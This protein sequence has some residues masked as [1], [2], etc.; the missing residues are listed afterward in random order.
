MTAPLIAEIVTFRIKPDADAHAFV[1]RAS[2]MMPILQEKAAF[3]R[4]ALSRDDTGLW[5]DHLEWRSLPEA[6]DAARQM[7]EHPTAAPFLAL[8]DPDSVTMRHAKLHL[9][10]MPD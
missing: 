2:D 6:L 5:T 1:A 7:M 9:T 10:A 4:R 8:I 3:R